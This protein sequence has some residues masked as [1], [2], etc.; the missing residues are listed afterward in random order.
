[1]RR[2]IISVLF[3]SFVSLVSSLPARAVDFCPA[4]LYLKPVGTAGT[5]Y[6]GA[7]YGFTLNSSGPKTVSAILAFE[8]PDNWFSAAV[9][10][11][12]IALTTRHFIETSG[13]H[14]TQP[15]WASPTMY[16]RFPRPV[17]LINAFVLGANG[18]ACPPTQRWVV[19]ANN[20]RP[21]I[22]TDPAYPDR[23]TLPPAAGDSIVV[24]KITRQLFKTNCA[25]PFHEASVTQPVPPERPEPVHRG[26]Q[27]TAQI[28]VILNPGGSL[29]EAKV[30]QSS[31]DINY[32]NAALRAASET[33]YQ[34][35]MA[36]C[37]AVPGSYLFKVT[38]Q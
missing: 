23:A 26:L 33:T 18:Q 4:S 9:P 34:S 14:T 36:Y 28:M 10:A 1:M 5:P 35:A 21:S 7:L 17:A 2:V 32:D 3:L 29:A 38:F 22:V 19:R 12:T 8:T 31:G 27:G 25:E 24:P 13:K 15:V 37:Q 6:T 11:T 16:L 20:S 30:F